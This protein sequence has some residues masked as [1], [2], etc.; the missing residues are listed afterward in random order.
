MFAQIRDYLSICRN[1]RIASCE[2]STLS[3]NDELPKDFQKIST[4][5]LNTELL[6][7]ILQ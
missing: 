4:H 1:N 3:F 6:R 7:L 2:A 5:F